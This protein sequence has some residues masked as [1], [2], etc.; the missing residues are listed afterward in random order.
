MA[1]NHTKNLHNRRVTLSKQNIAKK[2]TINKVSDTYLNLLLSKA[3]II[4]ISH[5]CSCSAH[6]GPFLPMFPFMYCL[7]CH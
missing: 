6:A 3:T 7:H 1:Q 4:L 5:F 2:S